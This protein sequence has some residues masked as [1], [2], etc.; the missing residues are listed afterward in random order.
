MS[1][2]MI[3][4]L[5]LGMCRTKEECDVRLTTGID[6]TV[7]RDDSCTEVDIQD[8]SSHS[9]LYFLYSTLEF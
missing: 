4:T 7:A 2:Q 3:R 9:Q 1:P 5:C 8:S 6:R